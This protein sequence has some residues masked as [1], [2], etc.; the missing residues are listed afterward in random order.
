MSPKLLDGMTLSALDIQTLGKPAPGSI[1]LLT[2]FTSGAADVDLCVGW[3]A[4]LTA[5]STVASVTAELL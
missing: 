2:L 3:A 5:P 4:D 1:S